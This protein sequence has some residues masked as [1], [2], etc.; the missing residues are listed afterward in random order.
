MIDEIQKEKNKSK[1]NTL[2]LK[3]IFKCKIGWLP[4]ILKVNASV[5][6]VI[7]DTEV[8]CS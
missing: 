1:P 2:L 7:E 4:D 6:L 3:F 8:A 5:A